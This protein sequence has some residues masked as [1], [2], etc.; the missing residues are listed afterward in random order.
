MTARLPVVGGDDN[1]WGAILN[2]FLEVSL[3]S[4]GTIQTTA[5]TQAGGEV[6]SNK[7]Q[8]SGYAGLNS[9]GVI[10]VA[11]LPANIPI[12]SLA[13][14]GTPSSSN[15]LRGDGSW[16]T[17]NSGSSSL[18]DDTDVSIASPANN[19]VLTYDSATS[20][21]ENVNPA[22]SSVFGRT[23]A[24]TS[25][26]GDYTA[27]QVGALPNTDDLSAI[28]IANPTAGN[29]S[30][31][32]HKITNLA[33]GTAAS[34]A[35]TLGQVPLVGAAGSGASNALSANDPTTTNS[36]TPT[37]TA[38]GDLTGTYP[39][40]TLTSSS[41]VESIISAN[42]TVT[43]A[44]QKTNSLSDVAD[45]GSS[46][47]NIHVPVLTPAA[48]V[49]VANVSLSAPGATCDS[50]SFS[51][52]DLFLLAAQSTASQNGLWTWTGA[53]SALTRPTE[54]ASGATIKGRT[55]EIQNG[56]TYGGS[57]WALTTPTA[58]ITIDSSSQTW[59]NQFGAYVQVIQPS[60]DTTG[61]TDTTN[62]N[63]AL[64]AARL[65]ASATVFSSVKLTPGGVYTINATLICGSYTSFDCS[66]ATIN[67]AVGSNCQMVRNY[68]TA[69]PV[70][71][72]TDV[73]CTAGTSN[74]TSPILAA[75]AQVGQSVCVAAAG[76]GGV[77]PLT[78]L[79]SAVS[80]STQV[81]TITNPDGTALTSTQ[82]TTVASG[83]SAL[84]F[85]RDKSVRITGGWWNK[86]ACNST[87]STQLSISALATTDAMHGISIKHCDG[88]VVTPQG[89]SSTTYH[90]GHAINIADDTTVRVECEGINYDGVGCQVTGPVYEM[91]VT[92]LKGTSQDDG[93]AFVAGD[94]NLHCESSG[95]IIGISVGVVDVAVTPG[96]G[97]VLKLIAGV[98][99]TVDQ[100]VVYGQVRGSSDENV[101]CFGDGAG[102][103][104]T[105]G[106]NY[107][108]IDLGTVS[109]VPG[110]SSYSQVGI[111]CPNV[112]T[113]RVKLDWPSTSSS[114]AIAGNAMILG[115]TSGGTAINKLIIEGDVTM[116]ANNGSGSVFYG[117]TSATTVNLLEFRGLH[118]VV[119]QTAN[120]PSIFQQIAGFTAVQVD[121]ISPNYEY[122]NGQNGYINW[123]N[124]SSG[125]VS[126]INHIGGRVVGAANMFKNAGQTGAIVISFGGGFE[127][128]GTG[129]I[130]DSRAG[131]IDYQIGEC[132][133][134]S[135]T[136]AAF[137]TSGSTLNFYGGDGMITSGSFTMLQR[138]ASESVSA[139]G[140]NLPF[141]LAMLTRT[142]GER[143]MDASNRIGKGATMPAVCTTTASSGWVTIAGGN[144]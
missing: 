103:A 31:N 90:Q 54:F 86:G 66:D 13:I 41:N 48:A 1:D 84:L 93:L 76:G 32:S 35:A 62:I 113:L 19:Q 34:D 20:K 70:A 59:N 16:A 72:A 128:S 29:I 17:P 106:G 10:P 116:T 109:G 37:G 56:T 26:S 123:L 101:V 99:N 42:S 28:A 36:R 77:S 58:G 108:Y 60:G 7:G 14:T 15:F 18:A 64:N 24:I 122:N 87:S 9:S 104:R 118:A 140:E 136:N 53:S 141:D 30:L 3:N 23:G 112:S 135:I 82:M 81:I 117:N 92:R 139:Y 138:S 47:A 40:P 67:L 57:T 52:G 45:A 114:S 83:G 22:V 2:T 125:S 121:H 120:Y 25:Q 61:A 126:R 12:A 115:N 63:K 89:V 129:R 73:S 38:G 4:D 100:V 68:S 8:P 33:D 74:I 49:A 94:W 78:G 71:G 69:N 142:V 96:G 79:I 21:W 80:T 55:I 46:R 51:S 6:T 107:G 39:N 105:I 5:L 127:V 88:V 44:L 130:A 134:D 85:N 144:Y 131:T 119:T 133:F 91:E 95:N 27:S 43:A 137:Y 98:G 132:K 75:V 143:C 111:Y 65:A 124:T 102:D 50:Y 110:G 97:G 11:L